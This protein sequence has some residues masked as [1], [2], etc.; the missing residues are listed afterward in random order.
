MVPSWD[1]LSVHYNAD[2]SICTRFA[3]VF[4]VLAGGPMTARIPATPPKRKSMTARAAV[5]RN[6]YWN[7]RPGPW[8]VKATDRTDIADFYFLT[9]LPL[10]K[11]HK[12]NIETCQRE[13]YS[14]LIGL[15]QDSKLD[16]NW[17]SRDYAVVA[18][19]VAIAGNNSAFCPIDEERIAFYSREH[20]AT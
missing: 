6:L 13:G 12:R 2:S 11:I 17:M 15:S 4:R 20:A 16:V 7:S 19:G 10:S 18:D 1:G 14:S 5:A 9:V 3:W 8:Y